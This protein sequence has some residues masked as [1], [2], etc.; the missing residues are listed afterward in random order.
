MES[1]AS[2]TT[3]PGERRAFGD[4]QQSI[5]LLLEAGLLEQVRDRANRI[6][7]EQ[8]NTDIGILQNVMLVRFWN[9][10]THWIIWAYCFGFEEEGRN[11]CHCHVY[12]KRTMSFFAARAMPVSIAKHFDLSFVRLHFFEED[13][14]T[15]EN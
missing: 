6:L 2:L 7:E 1:F 3:I 14:D 11:V 10:P 5:A 15:P 12:P 13:A 8:R 9:H 4:H